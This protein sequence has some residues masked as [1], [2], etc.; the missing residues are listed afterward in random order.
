MKFQRA[1]LVLIAS[2]LAIASA[3]PASTSWYANGISGGDSNNCTSAQ[4]ACKTIDGTHVE[5]ITDNQWEDG[6]PAWQPM[7]VRQPPSQQ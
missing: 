6:T 7:G 3:A 5:Q 4:T 1:R 2:F